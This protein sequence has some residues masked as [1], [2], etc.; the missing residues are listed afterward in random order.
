LP[1]IP[2]QEIRTDGRRPADPI[3]IV[4]LMVLVLLRYVL[5]HYA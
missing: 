3:V 2:I 1:D 4:L 5:Q